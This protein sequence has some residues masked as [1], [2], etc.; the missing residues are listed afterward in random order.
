MIPNIPFF[1]VHAGFR[2][3]PFCFEMAL[4]ISTARDPA[5]FRCVSFKKICTVEHEASGIITS[6]LRVR[7]G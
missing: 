5:C 4:E 7:L 2:C 3:C 6:N 1:L